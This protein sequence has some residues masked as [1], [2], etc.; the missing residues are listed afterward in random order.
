VLDL[1]I[2]AVAGSVLLS[3][4]LTMAQSS[5]LNQLYVSAAQVPTN[6]VTVHTYAAPPQGFNPVTATAEDL[7][8]YGFPQRPD[9]QAELQHYAA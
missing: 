2:L 8:A 5:A 9:K 7:A 4:T 3:P 6:I 1:Q